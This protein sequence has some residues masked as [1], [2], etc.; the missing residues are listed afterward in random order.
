LKEASRALIEM[1]NSRGGH[2]NITVVLI[3]VPANFKLVVR[4]HINWLPWI[5]GGI[6]GA[7]LLLGAVSVFAL[8]LLT[9]NGS[10]TLTPTITSTPTRTEAPRATATAPPTM[11]IL[12]TL[13]LPIAPTYTPWPT[14]TGTP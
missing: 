12:P 4:K 6:A 11:T 3:A 14:N 9:L 1:A 13:S 2:D 5:I 8:G 10:A 7:I